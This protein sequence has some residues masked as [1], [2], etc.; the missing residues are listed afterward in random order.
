MAAGTYKDYF[1]IAIAELA[2]ILERRD[3]ASALYDE[4]PRPVIEFTNKTGATNVI[5]NPLL[6]LIDDLDKT[7]LAYWRDLGLTPAG[8]R[9]INEK[10]FKEKEEKANGLMDRLIELRK[11]QG[12]G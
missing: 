3:G 4:D 8:L 11:V 10:T 6:V 12:N 1:E 2:I 5:K 9:K 7:A